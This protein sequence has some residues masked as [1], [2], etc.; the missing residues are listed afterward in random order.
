MVNALGLAKWRVVLL[1]AGIVAG[2]TASCAK[3]VGIEDT[4]V[5]EQAGASP[6]AGTSSGGKGGSAGSGAGGRA[7][8]GGAGTGGSVSSGGSPAGGAATGG[9]SAAGKGGSGGAAGGAGDM[10]GGTGGKGGTG[11]AGKGAGGSSATGGSGTEAGSGGESGSS[12]DACGGLTTRCTDG[13]RE[14]CTDGSWQ[15]EPCPLDTPTCSSG[16]C[17]VRGP[18]MV[19]VESFYIDSTE[20]TVAQYAEFTDA[21]NGDTSGQ[22][23][24]CSWNTSYDPSSLPGKDDWPVSYVDWCDAA[25]YCAWADKHLCGGIGSAAITSSN[26]FDATVSQWFLACGGGGFHPNSDPMCNSSDGFD[27]VAPVGSFPGCEG[28]VSGL[29]DMEG[30]VAEWVDYCD[31]DVGADDL[32]HPLGGSTNDEKSYCDESYDYDKRS[33][34]EY[35]VGF[36]CC[37][38]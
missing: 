32:C 27:D 29:F 17:I 37:S 25:A 30:N 28:Y 36:R 1:S 21:K 7:A 14:V 11:A 15:P 34:T 31:A 12:G 35:D 24:A 22:T 4:T 18:T 3:I 20:V 13:A 26:V 10:G 38:G 2:V 33:D 9:S 16:A 8:Q 23:S 19:K 5:E 6:S